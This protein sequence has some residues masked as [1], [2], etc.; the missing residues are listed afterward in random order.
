MNGYIALILTALFMMPAVLS[1]ADYREPNRDLSFTVTVDRPEHGS[2]TLDPAIPPDGKAPAGAMITVAATPERGYAFD[3]GYYAVPGRW[4]NMYFESMTPS[5]TVTVDRDMSI[6]ASFI[7]K[8]RLHGFSVTQDVVYAQPGVK[9]LKYDVFSPDGAKNLPCIVIIHGGGWS[10]NTEDIMRGLAR[11]LVKDGDYVVFSI[12]YRWLGT[13]DGDTVPN[14][15]ADLIG[16]VYGAIAHIQEHATEYGGDPTRVAVTGDSAGG[17]LA[18]AAITMV[19]RI[20]AGGFG[21]KPGVFEFLPSYLPA[22]KT[23]STVRHEIT[24]ALKAAAP[25]YGVF[26]GSLLKNYAGNPPDESRLRAISPIDHIPARSERDIPHYLLRGT[27]DTLI[28]DETVRSYADALKAAGQ[29]AIHVE[30]EG[31][32]HAFFDWKPDAITKATFEKYGVPYAAEMKSFFDSVFHPG[33]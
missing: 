27:N 6:G 30:V 13:L 18:A 23:V 10:T 8:E 11:E 28:T 15:M 20:G 17:H 32:N 22:D 14:T 31:A 9:K 3:G 25:S 21:E 29:R 16:D 19:D 5:F 12:D 26:G 7:E 2:V 1:A 4:G 24:R 33:R